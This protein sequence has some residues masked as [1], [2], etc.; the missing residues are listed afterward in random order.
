MVYSKEEHIVKLLREF[1]NITNFDINCVSEN[2]QVVNELLEPIGSLS[3]GYGT[4]FGWAPDPRLEFRI[5]NAENIKYINCLSKN[6]DVGFD[7]WNHQNSFW[8]DT[9]CSNFVH[10]FLLDYQCIYCVVQKERLYFMRKL[11][12]V[13]VCL[14]R[15][16]S[17]ASFWA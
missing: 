9:E 6:C 10:C 7:T 12:P 3:N 2:V 16:R 4:G 11:P 1:A 8:I 13:V 14:Q 17:G 5:I 15:A